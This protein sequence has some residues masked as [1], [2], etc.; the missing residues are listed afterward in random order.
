MVKHFNLFLTKYRNRPKG[1]CFTFSLIPST[2]HVFASRTIT[3]TTNMRHRGD[4]C[5]NSP[6]YASSGY[7]LQVYSHSRAS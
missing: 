1:M 7:I 5:S 2:A 4:D 3:V 6:S